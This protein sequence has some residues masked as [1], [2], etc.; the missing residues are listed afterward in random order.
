MLER[1][2]Y[3]IRVVPLSRPGS[4]S[5]NVLV[6]EE[7]VGDAQDAIPGVLDVPVVPPQVTDLPQLCVVH[8]GGHYMTLH[9][10]SLSFLLFIIKCNLCCLFP[11]SDKQGVAQCFLTVCLT[12][13]VP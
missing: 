9:L 2:P 6:F 1:E 4:G 8:L 13:Q 7:P 3:H 11:I 10:L 5:N 12:P